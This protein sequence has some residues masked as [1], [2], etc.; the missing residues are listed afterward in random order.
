MTA[1]IIMYRVWSS[2]LVPISWT[3]KGFLGSGRK[4]GTSTGK[5]RGKDGVSA[6]SKVLGR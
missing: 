3:R 5:I 4:Y 2:W 1:S 6:S